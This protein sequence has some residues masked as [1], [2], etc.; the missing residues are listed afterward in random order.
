MGSVRRECVTRRTLHLV[1]PGAL[2]QRTGGYIYDA[3]MTDGLRARGWRV[4]VHSLDGRFPLAD[5]EARSN[6]ETVFAEIPCGARVVVDGL[7]LAAAPGPLELHR[8]RLDVLAL[9]HHPLSEE[10]GLDQ[11]TRAQ[12]AKLES[13]ALKAVKGVVVTSAFTARGL[14]RFGVDGNRVRV[15]TPGTDPAPLALGPPPDAPLQ[16]LVVASVIP[17]KGHEVLVRALDR[18]RDRSWDCVCAGS[19]K[20]DAPHAQGVIA[21]VRSAG[22][23]DRIHFVGECA[24]GTLDCLYAGASLFVL[25][26]YYEGYGMVLSEALARGLPIVSTTGGAIPEVVPTEVG[27]LVQPGDD[28]ALSEAVGSFIGDG[29]VATMRFRLAAAARRYVSRIRSWDTAV[30]AMEDALIELTPELAVSE[31][32]GL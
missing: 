26:S 13:Q 23:L 30:E 15:V 5:E 31:D 10:T 21:M 27:L 19:L 18:L 4:D 29:P 9:V 12:V 3:R 7:A 16:L 28:K 25:P 1:V 8:K 11:V 17:R 24:R 22:L 6:L 20:R 2:D 32:R 14:D